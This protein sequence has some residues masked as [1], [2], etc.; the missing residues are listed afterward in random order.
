[1]KSVK[2]LVF[3]SKISKDSLLSLLQDTSMPTNL[4]SCPGRD[5]VEETWHILASLQPEIT[6]AMLQNEDLVAERCREAYIIPPE[7]LLVPTRR[8][9]AFSKQART[10]D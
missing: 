10:L 3:S 5:Q 9:G 7:T 4:E 6:L 2:N 1:M 8:L